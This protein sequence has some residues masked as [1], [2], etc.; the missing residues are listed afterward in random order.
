MGALL[1]YLCKNET[2]IDI[3]PSSLELKQPYVSDFGEL[4]VPMSGVHFSKHSKVLGE[5]KVPMC[6]AQLNQPLPN[7]SYFT[8][9]V[10]QSE[11]QPH[12]PAPDGGFYSNARRGWPYFALGLLVGACALV[13]YIKYFG[14][15]IRWISR[16]LLGSEVHEENESTVGR[17]VADTI[18]FS[19]GGQDFEAPGRWGRVSGQL[20][21]R[22][23]N[24]QILKV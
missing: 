14:G 3:F 7:V 22:N 24:F 16:L 2:D 8:P 1:A 10:N 20:T 18:K 21:K 23:N 17:D 13:A 15:M 9:S 19:S 4:P 6:L 12:L 11:V 5:G